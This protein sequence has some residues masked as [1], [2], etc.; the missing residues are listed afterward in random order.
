MKKF[1]TFFVIVFTIFNFFICLNAYSQA[2]SD[3]DDGIT[4]SLKLY[5]LKDFYGNNNDAVLSFNEATKELTLYEGE[6][7]NVKAT[8]VMPQFLRNLC[9]Y[10]SNGKKQI[11]VALGH[12][13]RDL[14]A[15][16]KVLL[17]DNNLKNEKTI[18]EVQSE[19]SDIPFIKQVNDDIYISYF[20]SKYYTKF[21][22]LV[23]NNNDSWNFTEIKR[24]RLGMNVDMDTENVV[25]ARPYEDNDNHLKEVIL[26]NKNNDIISLP[27]FR[28]TRAVAFADIDGDEQN[29]ILIA[30]GWHQDYGNLAE[31]RLS[32]LT[33]NSATN[34]YD[35]KL[36]DKN[37]GQYSIEKII[38]FTSN[39]N[40][41]ILA[42]GMKYIDLYEPKNNWK[43]TR[44]A[45]KQ[46]SIIQNFNAIF[47]SLNGKPRIV[48]F[49]KT[50]E[51]KNF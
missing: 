11:V 34:N 43:E 31:A 44:I 19:R 14:N 10:Q 6:A 26:L 38:P 22:K 7:L 1:N 4:T 18:F 12:G 42:V 48:M 5:S 27:S 32:L 30:D 8:K 15:P 46:G 16:I 39:N 40:L 2:Q 24:I 36:I 3:E 9:L 17:M 35:L 23:K 37:D 50:L 20:D 47:A 28:G 25:F 51:V 45:T 21:G 29:E 33:F 41:Y 49:D 13:K